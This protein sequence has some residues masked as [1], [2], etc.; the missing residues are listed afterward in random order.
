[1][2]KPDFHLC[3]HQSFILSYDSKAVHFGPGVYTQ[4]SHG[5]GS[6]QNVSQDG[7]TFTVTITLM[8]RVQ[9]DSLC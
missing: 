4:F 1:M 8:F 9:V 6:R 2:R 7:K 5:S 3:G